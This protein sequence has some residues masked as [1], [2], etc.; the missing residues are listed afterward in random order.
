[1]QN[2][3]IILSGISVGLLI[4]TCL[5]YWLYCKLIDERKILVNELQHTKQLL[6]EQYDTHQQ[7][8]RNLTFSHNHD[9]AVIPL[10]AEVEIYKLLLDNLQTLN[11]QSKDR[12]PNIVFAIHNRYWRAVN[13]LEK[14]YKTNA[15]PYENC[16]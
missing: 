15:N 9:K 12:I 11:K 4:I 2:I 14:K 1:M 13:E 8:I 7:D 3:L 6:K 16:T 5:L 10:K